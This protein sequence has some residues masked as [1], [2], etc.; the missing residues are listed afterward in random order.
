MNIMS[1]TS[2][3]IKNNAS[4]VIVLYSLMEKEINAGCIVGIKMWSESLLDCMAHIQVDNKRLF[5]RS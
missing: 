1:T 5:K 4:R 3:E 2:P